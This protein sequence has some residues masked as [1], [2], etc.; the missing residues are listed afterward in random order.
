MGEV[1]CTFSQTE[2]GKCIGGENLF[3]ISSVGDGVVYKIDVQLWAHWNR[4]EIGSKQYVVNA[5]RFNHG[6]EAT[7]AWSHGIYID[8]RLEILRGLTKILFYLVDGRVLDAFI[9]QVP[10]P[11][12]SADHG[13]DG[14]AH[15]DEENLELWVF[16]EDATIDHASCR[17]R[18]IKRASYRFVKPVLLH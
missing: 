11:I 6:P 13:S 12:E 16:I 4:P 14:S 2:Q 10:V 8:V 1:R 18:R 5:A 3:A 7:C 9:V 17:Q 15:M